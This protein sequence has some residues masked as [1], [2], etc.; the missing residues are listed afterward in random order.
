MTQ[1]SFA[2][3]QDVPGHGA[4]EHGSERTRRCESDPAQPATQEWD[5]VR[6]GA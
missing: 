3:A 6:A 4:G 2:G 5:V 1:R